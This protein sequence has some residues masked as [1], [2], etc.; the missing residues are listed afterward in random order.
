MFTFESLISGQFNINLIYYYLIYQI[1]QTAF[2]YLLKLIDYIIVYVEPIIIQKYYLDSQGGGSRLLTD[3]LKLIYNENKDR[4]NRDYSTR[5]AHNGLINDTLA[6]GKYIIYIN[7]WP[8]IVNYHYKEKIN[9][10]RTSY[11]NMWTISTDKLFFMK[12]VK[13]SNKKDKQKHLYVRSIERGGPY[14]VNDMIYGV[15][16]RIGPLPKKSF[17]DVVL[18]DI[19]LKNLKNA[20][21]TFYKKP[22]FYS[23]FNIPYKFCILLSGPPGFGKTSI[24]KMLA[25]MYETD[26]HVMS[27]NS[28]NDKMLPY[29]FKSITG[30]SILA[31]EDIDCMTIDRDAKKEIDEKKEESGVTLSG[32]LNALDGIVVTEG[33]VVIM[34]TNYPE[35]LDAAL[36]RQERV[37]LH[38]RLEKSAEIYGKMIKRFFPDMTGDKVDK[39]SKYCLEKNMSLADLQAHCLRYLDDPEKAVSL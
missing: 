3:V 19:T 16:D 6:P 5:T 38:C 37:H 9:D 32:F 24:I 29:V 1:C 17:N 10:T 7:S 15:W 25:D 14:V 4:V 30:K 36:I 28:T 33:L 20:L 13:Q 18:D 39:Y 11:L 23:K 31:L 2:I 26:L 35:K 8:V 27:L 34:T 12:F 22:S 21:D